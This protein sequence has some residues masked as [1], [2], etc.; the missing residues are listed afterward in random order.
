[1]STVALVARLVLAVAFLIAGAAKLVD[2]LRSDSLAGFGVPRRMARPAGSILPLMELAAGGALLPRTSAWGGAWAAATLLVVFIAGISFNLARGRAPDCHCFGQLRVAPVGKATLLRNLVLF[3]LAVLVLARGAD[4]VGPSATAWVSE[5]SGAAWAGIAGGLAATF[6]LA[7]GARLLVALT[8][9]HGE[10]LIRIDALEAQLAEQGFVLA[11]GD[12]GRRLG[13]TVGTRA[14]RF[15]GTALDGSRVTLEELRS[16]DMPL[17]L[18][19]SDPGCGPCEALLPRI[20]QWQ[21][22]HG[23]QVTVAVITRGSSDVNRTLAQEH[24]VDNLVLQRDHEIAHA[25]E[26]PGTPGAVLV[27]PSG[28]IASPVVMGGDE[29]E[30]LLGSVLGASAGAAPPRGDSNGELRSPGLRISRVR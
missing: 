30:Q 6:V 11:T 3:G 21:R 16:P 7:T 1:M 14:P 23:S 5:L 2:P 27:G 26:V 4:H 19:F 13:L 20:G 10:L 17:L 15:E 8:R 24:G 18:V 22:E 9:S 25:Y 28:N 12:P 29:I